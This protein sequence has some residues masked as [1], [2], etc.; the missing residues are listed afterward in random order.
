MPNRGTQILQHR[1]VSES[2]DPDATRAFMHMK[3]FDLELHPREARRF[4]FA[5]S[6]LYLPSSY[7]GYVQYGAETTVRGPARPLPDDYFIHLPL[8]GSAQ[9]TNDNDTAACARR[10]RG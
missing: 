8:Q 9:V 5:A 7:I 6:A 4:D 3:E 2:R 1:R 10:R